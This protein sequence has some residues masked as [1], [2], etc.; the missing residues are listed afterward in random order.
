MEFFQESDNDHKEE[1]MD[2]FSDGDVE[3]KRERTRDGGSK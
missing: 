1:F 3:N 2:L